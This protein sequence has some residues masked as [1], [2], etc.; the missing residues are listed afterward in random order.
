MEERGVELDH[1]T[2]NR[3]VITDSPP[4]AEA[5]HRRKRHVWI[6]WRMD[7]T[8]RKVKGEWHDLY[9]A[10]DKDGKTIDVVLTKQR[11]EQAAK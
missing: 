2:I 3:W 8:Y 1:V 4:L 9:R 6:S 10:V 5:F 7:E 11:D